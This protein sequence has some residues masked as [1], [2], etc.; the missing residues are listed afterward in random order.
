M[1]HEHCVSHRANSFYYDKYNPHEATSHSRLVMAA[2]KHIEQADED[3][4]MYEL[5][6]ANKPDLLCRKTLEMTGMMC[7]C[8]FI[9]TWRQSTTKCKTHM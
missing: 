1:C 7:V 3:K 9:D 6:L 8:V 4:Q 5:L 2:D